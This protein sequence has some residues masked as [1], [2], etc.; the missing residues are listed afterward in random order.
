MKSVK[1]CCYN[2]VIL[3]FILESYNHSIA[4]ALLSRSIAPN[5]S[6]WNILLIYVFAGTLIYI[7]FSYCSV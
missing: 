3:K 6:A 2:V 4:K 1:Y 7:K 5:P